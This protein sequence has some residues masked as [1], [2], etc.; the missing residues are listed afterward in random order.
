MLIDVI[1]E[2]PKDS[3]VKYEKDETTNILRVDRI[4]PSAYVYPYNY[5]YVPHTLSEDGDPLDV[6]VITNEPLIPGCVIR[7]RIIGCLNT[8]DGEI[9]SGLKH[10]PK[11]IVVPDSKVDPSFEHMFEVS[12]YYKSVIEDFFRNYKNNEKKATDVRDWL[13]AKNS[14][15]IVKMSVYGDDI[16]S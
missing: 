10:D 5:G 6:M 9:E 12:C 2:I 11:V 15:K 14:D 1:I 4:L 7:C 16:I 13:D 3:R 8:Y